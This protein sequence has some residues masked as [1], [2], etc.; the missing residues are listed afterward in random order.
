MLAKIVLLRFELLPKMN[1][2]ILGVQAR[3]LVRV[4]LFVRDRVLTSF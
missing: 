3:T 4:K 1:M 2:I